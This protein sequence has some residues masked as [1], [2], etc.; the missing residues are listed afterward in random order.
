MRLSDTFSLAGQALW[1]HKTRTILTL[2]GVAAGS[3]LLI[4]SLSLGEGIQDAAAAR[5]RADDQLRKI[6]VYGFRRA[7]DDEMPAELLEI[8]GEMTA[9]K[10]ERLR[11]AARR[12][13]RRG[14]SHRRQPLTPA[15]LESLRNLAGVERVTPLV[16]LDCQVV[17]GAGGKT[18]ELA[19]AATVSHA[20]DQ[21]LQ[22]RLEAGRMFAAESSVTEVL[23]NEYLLYQ[24][25]F[26]SGQ[27][28][29]AAVGR[30]LRVEFRHATSDSLR[31]LAGRLPALARRLRLSKQVVETVQAALRQALTARESEGAKKPVVREFRI[32]GVFRDPTN[33]ERGPHGRLGAVDQDFDLVLPVA[34]GGE[35]A[36]AIQSGPQAGFDLATVTVASEEQVAAVEEEIEQLGL[37]TFS[38]Q[39][40]LDRVQANTAMFSYVLSFL[41]LMAL[42]VAALGI[43]NTM[44]MSVLERTPEI[45]VMKAIG[46]RD[47]QVQGIYLI[48]GALLG[49]LGGALGLLCAYLVSFPADAYGRARLEERFG[50]E[51]EH[52]L[53]SFPTWVVLGPTLLAA[54]VATLAAVY[55][56]RRAAKI[57]PIQAL[58][59]D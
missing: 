16:K 29:A 5:F 49:I 20:D 48:E 39:G 26:A 21:N 3:F 24:W 4:V 28:V 11:Q 1:R 22:Q 42:F 31:Q 15:R 6:R 38:L 56:A 54:A 10:R 23:V 44:A 59:R 19:A 52:S 40:I 55:P 17:L 32:A 35:I 51:I 34:A 45:G 57:D 41:A 46:A 27:E 2:S 36:L 37:D 25:G 18:G 43:T 30:T 47:R 9:A 33:A 53:F 7:A 50:V 12:R 58:K 14:Q 8:E 13:W